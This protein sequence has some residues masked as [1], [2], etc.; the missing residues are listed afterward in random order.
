MAGPAIPRG[1]NLAKQVA[2][3]IENIEIGKGLIGKDPSGNYPNRYI[4]VNDLVTS[5]V[6]AL[7]TRTGR[8]IQ[9]PTHSA[10]VTTGGIGALDNSIPPTPTGLTAT[11]GLAQ[12]LVEWDQIPASYTNPA[13]TEIWRNGVDDLGTATRVTT[14]PYP[15][16]LWSDPIGDTNATRYYWIRFVSQAE[17]DGPFNAIAGVSATTG[18][19]VNAN[20]ANGAVDVFKLADAAVSTTK[21]ASGIEPVTIVASVPG[22]LSTKT[23]YNTTDGKLYRW[24]GTAY[25]AAV[26]TTDLAGTITTTQISDGAI[27]T[28]KMTANAIN[29]DRITANTLDASKIVANSI[30]AGQIQ[31]GAISAT[32]IASKAISVDKLAVGGLGDNLILNP[33]FEQGVTGW[34]LI[35]GSGSATSTLLSDAPDGDYVMALSSGNK[36]YGCRAISVTPGAKYIV[37][38]KIKHTNGTGSFYFIVWEKSDYPSGD[39]IISSNKTSYTT[40]VNAGAN[41]TSW[42]EYVYTYTVPAGIYWA[43]IAVD[44]WGSST[45][46]LYVDDV[47]FRKQL[48]TANILDAAIVTAKIADAAITTAKIG[49]AQITTALINDAAITNAKIGTAAV[50]DAKIASASVSKLTAGTIT[51]AGIYVGDTHF[52]LDGSQGN[53]IVS[54]GTYN[55]VKLGNLGSGAYGI[56]IRDGSNNVIL[57]SGGTYSS[58]IANS[59][60]SI[61][62]AGALS[63]AGGGTVTITG[64]GYTGDLNATSDL[65]LVARG[66]CV[67]TGNN[68][69]K[70]GGTS[71]WDSDCYSKDAYTGGAFCSFSP[72]QI[73]KYFLIGLNSD[74]TTDQ[75]YTGIDYCWYCQ[76]SGVMSIMESGT[77]HSISG[78]YSA[79]DVFSIVY[80]GANVVYMINGVVKRTVSVNASLTLFLDSS[81]YSSGATANNVRFGPVSSNL[82]GSLGSTPANLA[83]LT[84]SEGIQ[85]TL[86]TIGEAS[87]VISLG[88][89]G[90]GSVTT[91]TA[92]NKVTSSNISTYIASAAIGYAQIGS[93]DATT[94]T[95]GTLA[96]ARI[97][98]GSIDAT[99]LSVS[100]LSAI[101]ANLGTITAGTITGSTFQT[102]SGTG[103]RAALSSST[104]DI[105][106]Y[107]SSNVL[108]AAIGSGV[109]GYGEVAYF[110]QNSVNQTLYAGND[111]SGDAISAYSS[112]GFGVNASSGYIGLRV[113]G[114]NGNMMLVSLNSSYASTADGIVFFDENSE[115]SLR[116]NSG[117]GAIPTS[118]SDTSYDGSHVGVASGTNWTPAH[119]FYAISISTTN[120][121]YEVYSGSAWQSNSNSQSGFFWFDGTNMRFHLNNS[122]SWYYRKLVTAFG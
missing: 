9:Y 55:R 26:D 51:A 66:N 110:K 52:L 24:N 28:P 81:F 27:T 11:A 65:V 108:N 42:T 115:L 54:D 107:N 5:G 67:A 43:T 82:W 86:V 39:Y 98:A 95:T 101:T 85:N 56:E 21:F 97:A 72:A 33:S 7:K 59:A 18:F 116:H 73:N 122:A 44:N 1:S 10:F 92:N 84:G 25:T 80:D 49:S 6:I 23:I 87:G 83:A 34:S 113:N 118:N 13:Y 114:Y 96:A 104:N 74:P 4:T 112:S 20:L 106:F 69:T 105:R 47:E 89:A 79:G 48:G 16:V 38:C 88:G 76:L 119:G 62:S 15:F 71:A 68:I 90:S 102:A 61:S 22:S 109:A 17:L 111:G 60:V 30:T 14:V 3:I 53:L 64:L 58:A 120:I 46:T 29:G 57:N 31:A 19:V 94:I 93:V 12:I 99:K 40:L 37:R 70:S 75:T 78:T 2:T 36:G 35:E 63:G 50:D 91:I 32:E 8:T 41:P 100:T 103:Q 77:N 121:V 117:W 45:G